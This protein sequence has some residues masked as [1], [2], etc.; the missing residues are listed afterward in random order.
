MLARP[1]ERVGSGR[2]ELNLTFCTIFEVSDVGPEGGSMGRAGFARVE[3]NG[4]QQH[5]RSY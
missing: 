2:A 3:P 4:R 1:A 5:V